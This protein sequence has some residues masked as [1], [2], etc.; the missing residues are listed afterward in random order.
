MIAPVQVDQSARMPLVEAH[1]VTRAFRT[2][3]STVVHALRGVSL[4][5][6]PGE[7]VALRGRSG[8]GKTTLLNILAGLDNPTSGSVKIL[9]HALAGM[10]ETHRARLR[11]ASVGMLFQNAHLFPLL[12]AQENVEV[13]LRL[14][15]VKGERRDRQARTM[16]EH[17][18]LGSRAHHRGLELS[19]GEQQ[20]VALARALV[21]KPRFVVA[22]EPT[23]NLD[24]MT[25]LDIVRLMR[26]MAHELDIGFLVATHDLTVVS[27]ADHVLRL[28]DGM[29]V[30]E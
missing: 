30:E 24:S 7:F 22:D 15:K 18:G 1:D 16:L 6:E 5:V 10:D 23:A 25:G 13:P 3:G 26:V 19:G 11:R 21:H 8:S 29:I 17:L 12:T 14:A 20:R 4:R 9:G 2:G 28:S 27:A